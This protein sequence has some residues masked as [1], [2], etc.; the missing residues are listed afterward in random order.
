MTF[1]FS[2]FLPGL[3]ADSPPGVPQRPKP[4]VIISI[5][6]WITQ[7]HTVPPLSNTSP[8]LTTSTAESTESHIFFGT[9]AS[10]RTVY[11]RTKWIIGRLARDLGRVRRVV[12]SMFEGLGQVTGREVG[13]RGNEE[14]WQDPSSL[15]T[16]TRS[17]QCP[18]HVNGYVS[19]V[20]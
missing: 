2:I 9:G 8:D 7:W 15:L 17:A 4:G 5:P 13:M 6:Q 19:T 10:A 20:L 16:V 18:G 14:H 3:H 1:A 11:V 12:N